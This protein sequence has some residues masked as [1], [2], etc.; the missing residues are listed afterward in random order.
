MMPYASN[1]TASAATWGGNS[2]STAASTT[3][4]DS[5][6]WPTYYDTGADETDWIAERWV[7]YLVWLDNRKRWK[8]VPK[9]IKPRGLSFLGKRF[10]WNRFIS[11]DWTGKN[12]RKI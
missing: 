2:N 11:R 6:Y 7:Q 3:T 8:E 12:F 1:S 5:N 4:C 9:T 10:I